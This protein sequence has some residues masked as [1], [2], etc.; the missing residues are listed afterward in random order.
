MMKFLGYYYAVHIKRKIN[1]EVTKFRWYCRENSSRNGKNV[2][3]CKAVI[4]TLNEK[5]IAI[6]KE[7]NHEPDLKK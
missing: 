4:Y 5:I 1:N 2:N 3:R 6:K 7:H